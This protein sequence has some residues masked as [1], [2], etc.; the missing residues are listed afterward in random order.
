MMMKVY[1]KCVYDGYKFCRNLNS[2]RKSLRISQLLITK[3]TAE[4]TV[5][6]EL[7]ASGSQARMLLAIIV[8][9]KHHK[10][11]HLTMIC[12]KQYFLW[13]VTVFLLM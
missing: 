11:T 7:G 3:N 12:G 2:G 10:L 9:V 4:T 8:Y 5:H 6:F 13:Y 1:W